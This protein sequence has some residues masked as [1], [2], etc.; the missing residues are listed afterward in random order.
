MYKVYSGHIVW[1]KKAL[2][3]KWRG[4]YD[5]LGDKRKIQGVRKKFKKAKSFSI[6]DFTFFSQK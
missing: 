2:R 3:I 4:F 6:G 1:Y 5:F